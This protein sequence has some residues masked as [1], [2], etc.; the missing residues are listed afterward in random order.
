[1]TEHRDCK[2][3]LGQLS[4]YL[5]GELEAA[6]CDEIERHMA[7]CENCRIVV[8]TLEKTVAF[9]R[10]M[11]APEMPAEVAERLFQKLKLADYRR[12]S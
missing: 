6:L 2:D 12:R 3:L 1:M 4:A 10:A 11:P 8:N 7:D 5:D 9:Y